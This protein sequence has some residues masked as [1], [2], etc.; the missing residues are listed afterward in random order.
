MSARRAIEPAAVERNPFCDPDPR[1]A[2]EPGRRTGVDTQRSMML[3]AA[4]TPN[5]SRTGP[6]IQI[7]SSVG[8]LVQSASMQTIRKRLADIRARIAEAD[9]RLAELENCARDRGMSR[10]LI[11]SVTATLELLREHEARLESRLVPVKAGASRR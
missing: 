4:T 3:P 6:L 2:A 10:M 11:D 7:N 8:R 1:A 9:H 5:E